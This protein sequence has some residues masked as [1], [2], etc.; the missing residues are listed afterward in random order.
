MQYKNMSKPVIAKTSSKKSKKRKHIEDVSVNSHTL[1]I[2]SNISFL[3]LLN[4]ENSLLDTSNN[5]VL[6]FDSAL[7]EGSDILVSDTGK[8]IVTLTEGIYRFDIYFTLYTTEKIDSQL[9][10]DGEHFD[11]K[12]DIYRKLN[13][14][15]DRGAY[16]MHGMVLILPCIAGQQFCFKFK[17]SD[18]TTNSECV[19]AAGSRVLITKIR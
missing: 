15:N 7:L 6:R 19:F 4:S 12:L 9:F 14:I 18:E 8:N 1:D 13:L 2:Q 10:I 5:F 16:N 11:P 17:Y 3:S